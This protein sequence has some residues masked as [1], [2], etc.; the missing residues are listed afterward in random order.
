MEGKAGGVVGLS[1]YLP[2]SGKIKKGRGEYVKDGEMRV[3]LGDGTKDIL[4]PVS[5][6]F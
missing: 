2:R 5:F 4:V 1:G 6:F 3:F